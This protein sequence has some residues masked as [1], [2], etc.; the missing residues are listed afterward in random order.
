MQEWRGN[1]NSSNKAS[2]THGWLCDCLHRGKDL[3]LRAKFKPKSGK[4]HIRLWLVQSRIVGL[5]LQDFPSMLL[6]YNAGPFWG[7][8]IILG[9]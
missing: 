9:H 1:K 6:I 8:L 7:A 5:G 2:S 4:S 3:A